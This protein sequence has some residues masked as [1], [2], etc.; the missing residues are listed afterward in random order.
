MKV[1]YEYPVN[2]AKLGRECGASYYGLL[3]SAGAKA[4]SWFLY[5]KTKGR[6]EQAIAELGYPKYVIHRPGLLLHREND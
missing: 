2:F 3:S 1:D 5:M 4:S 6:V